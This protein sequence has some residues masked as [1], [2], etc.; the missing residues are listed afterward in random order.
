[1]WLETS[2]N[3]TVADPPVPI[4]LPR[5]T[6]AGGE[7]IDGY[8]LPEKVLCF[9]T[10]TPLPRKPCVQMTHSD[11]E[12]SAA[13]DIHRMLTHEPRCEQTGISLPHWAAYQCE[14]NWTDPQLFVPER[15]LDTE[16]RYANDKRDVLQPF[17]IGPRN[18]IGKK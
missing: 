5:I 3:K 15:W 13:H 17:S 16:T 14:Q 6:P 8:Y 18:C 11:T 2:A 9:P 4:G 12:F 1:M 7:T 10:L